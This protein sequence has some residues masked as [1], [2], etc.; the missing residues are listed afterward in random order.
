M[1]VRPVAERQSNPLSGLE[2][3]MY[4]SV[5]L[6]VAL[7]TINMSAR[8]EEAP[9]AFPRRVQGI[10]FPPLAETAPRSET[11]CADRRKA[12]CEDPCKQWANGQSDFQYS[13]DHCVQICPKQPVFCR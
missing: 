9:T 12:V 8:S 1:S 4:R 5:I 7:L 6:I 10:F 2:R 11:D 13:Y 3:Y